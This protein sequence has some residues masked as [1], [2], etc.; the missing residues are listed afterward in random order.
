LL[1]WIVDANDDD[2]A[3]IAESAALAVVV[4]LWAAWCMPCR[5]V[6]RA[7]KQ[8]AT[9]MAGRLELVK[10]GIDQAPKLSERFAARARAPSLI[11]EPWAGDLT[12]GGR[13]TGAVIR[14]WIEA[15]WRVQT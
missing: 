11:D 6:S 7:L 14:R 13:G 2:L 9:E 12:P 3:E 10:V 8:V 15:G 4:D 5:M 1:P